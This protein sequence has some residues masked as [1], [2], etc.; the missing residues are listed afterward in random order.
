[1]EGTAS[2]EAM[3]RKA[4][5]CWRRETGEKFSVQSSVLTREISKDILELTALNPDEIER[6]MTGYGTTQRIQD[7][8][9]TF[10]T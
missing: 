10:G 9:A 8:Q 2:R 4:P 1:M 5:L 7:R 3:G 6:G